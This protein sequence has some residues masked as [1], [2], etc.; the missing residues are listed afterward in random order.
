MAQT[1]T[2]LCKIPIHKN[3]PGN[4]LSPS[5][6]L[7]AHRKLLLQPV[8][9][10]ETALYLLYLL[11][12]YSK[13][14][15]LASCGFQPLPMAVLGINQPYSLAVQGLVLLIQ[16]ISYIKNI[17]QKLEVDK[18]SYVCTIILYLWSTL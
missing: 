5:S 6:Q 10:L 4:W 13:S 17:L 1:F 12:Q 9:A 14:A 15:V 8:T 16:A 11:L 7:L 3:Y 18:S 2:V